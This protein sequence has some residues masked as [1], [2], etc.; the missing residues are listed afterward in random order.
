MNVEPEIES[1]DKRLNSLVAATVVV[2]SVFLAVCNIKDGNIVQN[3]QMQKADEVDSWGEYQGT[4]LK[5]G[6]AEATL[7]QLRVQAAGAAPGPVAD[8]IAREMAVQQ[9]V[10]EK[11]TKQAAEQLK[12]AQAYRPAI[13]ALGVTDD[14][15]DISE[16]FVS[17][18]IAVA[19]VS[20][21]VASFPLL[22]LAWGSG[23]VGIVMGLAG[24]LG[25]SVHP[26]WLASLLT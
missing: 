9:G 12:K 7:V 26:A 16:A 15:F 18:A 11:Q 10:V 24:F 23:L 1:K 6:L 19:A 4:K 5:L 3:M 22:F 20:A 17:I 13:E 21:L 2:L 14:Q 25:W 8:V